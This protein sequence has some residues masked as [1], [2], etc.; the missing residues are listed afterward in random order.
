MNRTNSLRLACLAFALILSACANQKKMMEAP[1]T[2]PGD[3]LSEDYL[4]GNWCT[5]RELTSKSNR[6]AGHSG[7]LNMRP[8]FWRLKQGG[9]WQV[10][11]SGWLY[12]NHGRWRL[13]GLDNLV[14]ERSEGEPVNYQ[15]SFKDLALYLKDEEGK[16]LVLA[17]CE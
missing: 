4:I 15:A 14:L 9:E 6:D 16:F 3:K 5:D 11:S 13:K 1:D 2:V 17:G 10:S 7:M 8:L 12:E